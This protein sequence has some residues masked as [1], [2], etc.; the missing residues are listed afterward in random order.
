MVV[1]VRT[2]RRNLA[3]F[4]DR[5]ARGES[6]VVLRHGHPWAMLRRPLPDERCRALSVTA[7]RDDLRRGLLRARRSSVRLTWRGELLE[8][9]V[10]AV[11]SDI[12]IEVEELL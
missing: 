11:P 1:T 5:A 3:D 7:F 4:A 9:V 12:L 8:V 6:I 2:L 10:S